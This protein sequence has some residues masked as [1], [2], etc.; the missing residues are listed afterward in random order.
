MAQ[1]NQEYWRTR[2]LNQINKNIR[3]SKAYE[4]SIG[5]IYDAVFDNVQKEI[6]AFYSNY[7]GKEGISMAEAKQR[8][9]QLDMDR[10][11]KKAARYVKEK[12]FS[13]EANAEMRLYNLTMKT[14][15]LELLKANIGLETANGFSQVQALFQ[16]GLTDK[17]L[18][19]MNRQAG[20]LGKSIS[21]NAKM[22]DSIV[23]AS[24]NN[25][26]YTQRVW[27]YQDLLKYELHKSLTT[28]LIQGRNPRVLAKSVRDI[29][30][31]SKQNAERLM[32]TEMCRVQIE[33]QKQSY[34]RNGYDQ[35]EYIAEPSACKICKTLDGKNFKVDKMQIASNAPPMHPN[36]LC[37]TAA[38]MDRAE[39][40][41]EIKK[42]LPESRIMEKGTG[43]SDI[44]RIGTSEVDSEHLRSLEYKSKFSGISSNSA[45]NEALY[46]N[47]VKLLQEHAGGDTEGLIIVNSRT[48]RT[49]LNKTGDKNALGVV[50]SKKDVDVIRN[51]K[52][53]VVAIHNHPTNLYPTGS[54][55]GTAGYRGYDFGVVATHDGRIFKYSTGNTPFRT[56]VIDRRVDK[57]ASAPY[58]IDIEKAYEKALNEIREEYGISWQEIK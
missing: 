46:N 32:R 55:F 15:R 54:D 22:A 20:I 17:A 48:G 40:M 42:M 9:S 51:H 52:S 57:Y 44:R 5:G 29:F 45:L 58:N 18:E 14:N 23:N 50:L 30:G 24:F 8:A 35:Y 16:D 4:K 34:E 28:G 3:D 37:S 12:N 6:D 53:G 49:I 21:N 33:A 39:T 31:A 2:E 27:M 36:C 10:Y 1:T 41:K 7:A 25:A 56:S 26:T 13:A 38:Y 43:A 19:E 47:A 11:S